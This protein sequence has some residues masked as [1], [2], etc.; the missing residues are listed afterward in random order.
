MSR[1][2][3]MFDIFAPPSYDYAMTSAGALPPGVAFFCFHRELPIHARWG[4]QEGYGEGMLLAAQQAGFHIVA[5]S[6][7]PDR[8]HLPGDPDLLLQISPNDGVDVDLYAT[9]VIMLFEA[10]L[11]HLSALRRGAR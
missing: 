11:G 8:G 7:D 9:R 4:Q 5:L 10:A 1:K 3:A 2:L 6:D